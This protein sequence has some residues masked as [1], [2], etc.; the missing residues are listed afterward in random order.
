M[1]SKYVKYECKVLFILLFLPG[2]PTIAFFFVMLLSCDWNAGLWLVHFDLSPS[3]HFS[4]MADGLVVVNEINFK[5][6][7]RAFL[8]Q[9]QCSLWAK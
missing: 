9:V 2:F 4:F 7:F 3:H 8:M 6:N 1:V 5:F